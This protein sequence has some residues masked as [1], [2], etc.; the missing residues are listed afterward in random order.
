MELIPPQ[1]GCGRRQCCLCPQK[2]AGAPQGT[3]K[4]L[5]PKVHI[6]VLTGSRK[7]NSLLPKSGTLTSHRFTVSLSPG[8]ALRAWTCPAEPCLALEVFYDGPVHK[9]I[10]TWG[11]SLETQGIG[12]LS[13]ALR[14]RRLFQVLLVQW[15]LHLIGSCCLSEHNQE[16]KSSRCRSNFIPP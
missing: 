14:A 1:T 16:I 2:G 7:T 5:Q 9:A 12:P 6:L 15:D 10:C 4:S 11:S 13:Q 8:P 3:R